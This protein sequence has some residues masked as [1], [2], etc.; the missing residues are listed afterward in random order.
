MICMQRVKLGMSQ[1]VAKAWGLPSSRIQKDE[2]RTNAMAS[3]RIPDLCRILEISPN[4]LFGVS[5]SA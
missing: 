3:T 1:G 2:N 5:A 4:D